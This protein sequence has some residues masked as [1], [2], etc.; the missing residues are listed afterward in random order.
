MT[1]CRN[2]NAAK[3]SLDATWEQQVSGRSTIELTESQILQEIP[4]VQ[5]VQQSCSHASGRAASGA[6][7]VKQQKP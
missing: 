4:Q 7:G 2:E 6:D 1:G 3:P 5:F